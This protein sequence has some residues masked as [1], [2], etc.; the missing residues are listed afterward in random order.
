MHSVMCDIIP[1]NPPRPP[2]CPPPRLRGGTAESPCGGTT[3]RTS[4]RPRWQPTPPAARTC[5]PAPPASR[6]PSR[7]RAAPGPWRA[8]AEAGAGGILGVGGFTFCDGE[9]THNS[10]IHPSIHSSTHRPS[11]RWPTAAAPARAR[12]R[13]PGRPTRAWSWRSPPRPPRPAAPHPAPP[14]GAAPRGGS[15]GWRASAPW[16]RS[17]G[18][19]ARR[20][21]WSAAAAGRRRARGRGP[22]P[23]RPWRWWRVAGRSSRT[24]QRE[25]RVRRV[26]RAAAGLCWWSCLDCCCGGGGVACGPAPR[27]AKAL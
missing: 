10:W 14:R 19:Q 25:R 17:W 26:V 6:P 20:R 4:T 5:C 21:P 22:R 11:S 13:T 2:P 8:G 9:H 1:H 12:R 18:P 15:G 3:R 16:C 7:C 27:L 23:R 24:R